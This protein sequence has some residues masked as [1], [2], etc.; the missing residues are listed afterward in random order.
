LNWIAEANKDGLPIKA[1]V[2]GRPVGIL[3]GLEL[4]FNPFSYCPS[5]VAIFKLSF[6]ERRA[7]LR[8]PELR[9]KLVAEFPAAPE[10]VGPS[11]Y[12]TDLNIYVLGEPLNYEPSADQSV[13]SC[14]RR[15]GR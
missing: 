5:S 2:C 13:A 4:S 6:A 14:A 11:S 1:Q 10:L 7:A 12:M 3:M 8:Q 15:E 9:A